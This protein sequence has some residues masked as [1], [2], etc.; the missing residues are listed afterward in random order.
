MISEDL[1]RNKF[2]F[3]NEMD[4]D[5]SVKFFNTIRDVEV[6][7]GNQL[8]SERGKC[9]GVPMVLEGSIRVFKISQEGKEITLYRVMPGQICLLAAVCIM[10][11][12]DYNVFAEAL[13][14]CIILVMP[15]DYFLELFSKN[16]PWQ[17]FI[18]REMAKSLI[19][20]MDTVEEVAFSGIEKRIIKYLLD[21]SND[22][23]III[24]THEKIAFD[25]GTA[26]EV[27]SRKLQE[28]HKA[29]LINV[30][31]GKITILNKLKLKN[32]VYK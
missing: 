21:N 16:R 9:S 7:K 11:D 23:D 29:N 20:T 17:R 5:E 13:S 10:G 8:L 30:G 22:N 25:I 4:K 26:R 3:I 2:P 28:L 1:I 31:R 27:I 12:L 18:F 19:N 6:P 15:S 24:T 32:M 14:D